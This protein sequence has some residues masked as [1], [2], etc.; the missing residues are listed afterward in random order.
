MLTIA[1]ITTAAETVAKEFPIKSIVL[2][3]SYA[4]GKNTEQSDV[5]LLVEFSPDNC[6][7]LLTIS[8]IKIRMEELL[9]VPVDVITVPV[10]K[11]SILEIN[12]VVQLYAA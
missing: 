8:G 10:P 1:Q 5:D 3:G 11:D 12:K 6:I 2:F 4:E 9:D 7:T